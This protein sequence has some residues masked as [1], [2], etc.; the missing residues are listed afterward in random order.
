MMNN[1]DLFLF[2][3]GQLHVTLAIF[4]G[5][6]D[7][8]WDITPTEMGF[9]EIQSH[10]YVAKQKGYVYDPDKIPSKLGYKGFLVQDAKETHPGWLVG[11]ETTQL[12]MHLLHTMPIHKFEFQDAKRF[13]H[14][15]FEE[16]ETGKNFKV[17]VRS[18]KHKRYAYKYDPNPWNG[19]FA[20]LHNNCYNYANNKIT[21]TFAQPGRG[22][23]EGMLRVFFPASVRNAAINDGLENLET[24]PGPI[25]PVPRT[26]N[27]K[28]HLVALVVRPLG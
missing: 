28:K 11:S 5:R 26:P 1:F 7:P 15:V 13:M 27:G 19:L 3:A 21:D 23:G 2:A 16:I 22:S 14:E 8:E 17:Q 9:E 18:T 24:D 10:L 4:S 25:Q 20:M 12:Q 6:P